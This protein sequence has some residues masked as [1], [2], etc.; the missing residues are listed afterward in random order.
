MWPGE[1]FLRWSAC[2]DA[3]SARNFHD[4]PHAYSTQA[5][6]SLTEEWWYQ[7]AAFRKAAI[8]TVMPSYDSVAAKI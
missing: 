4:D 7:Q 3:P 2:I 6:L 5:G 8:A 1:E